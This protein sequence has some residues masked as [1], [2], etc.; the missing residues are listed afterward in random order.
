MAAKSRE[1]AKGGKNVLETRQRTQL[2][3]YYVTMMNDSRVVDTYV[4]TC[5]TWVMRV[6]ARKRTAAK[7][8]AR[9]R[10]FVDYDALIASL[11]SHHIA[12]EDGRFVHSSRA[13]KFA[14]LYDGKR[15]E[16]R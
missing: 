9:V 14:G 5:A 16:V 12:V 7:T 3:I 4:Y 6:C 15:E 13:F 8:T 2:R 1:S 10:L 11:F